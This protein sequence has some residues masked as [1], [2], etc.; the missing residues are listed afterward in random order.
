MLVMAISIG[1]GAA[2]GWLATRVLARLATTLELTISLVAA[3]GSYLLAERLGQ[4]GMIATVVCGLVFGSLGAAR[5]AVG[6]G[7]GRHR[8]GLG[9]HRASW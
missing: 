7:R 4:S 6:R 8:H 2:I 1:I 3:Y 9:V 5:G